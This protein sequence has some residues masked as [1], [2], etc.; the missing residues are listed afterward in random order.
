MKQQSRGQGSIIRD[1]VRDAYRAYYVAPSGRRVTKRFKDKKEATAWLAAQQNAANTNTFTE[2]SK[3]TLGAW[4]LTWLKDYKQA[5]ISQRTFERYV[6][7]TVKCQSLSSIKLQSITTPMV[8]NLYG[9][10]AEQGLSGSTIGKVHKILHAAMKKA[11]HVGLIPRNIIDTVEPPKM[12]H[13]HEIITFSPREIT[14]ILNS[15]KSFAKGRYYVFLLVAITTGMRLGEILA[16]RWSDIDARKREIHVSYNLQQT[17]SG[18]IINPPKTRAG[19]RIITVPPETMSAILSIKQDRKV[20]TLNG[21]IFRTRTNQPISPR[22]I[23]HSWK[24]LMGKLDIPYRNFHV[25]RH[26]HATDLLGI[27][28]PIVEVARRLG[29][30]RISHTLELYGHA[31]PSYDKEIAVKVGSL[32]LAK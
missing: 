18:I 7:L 15:A 11:L 30:A 2:P 24:R 1:E 16:L 26:T 25:I 6:E 19:K 32:Y 23:E 21:L 5:A 31:I 12:A 29:H 3:I 13:S 8:Q 9:Q 28:V 17:K 10:L 4:L 27:G 22:N 14:Q 20:E